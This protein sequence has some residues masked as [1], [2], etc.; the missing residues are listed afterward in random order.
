M[1]ISNESF[2]F[3]RE[4]VGVHKIKGNIISFSIGARDQKLCCLKQFGQLEHLSQK[5][6]GNKFQKV[7]IN[8]FL[9]E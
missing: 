4:N 9:I 3:F 7:H 8:F 2:E 1:S 6:P 5:S